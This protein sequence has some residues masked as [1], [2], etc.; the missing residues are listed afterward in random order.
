M[1]ILGADESGGSVG[2]EGRGRRDAADLDYG[3]DVVGITCL[4][5]KTVT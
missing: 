2:L 3:H 1:L 5:M 4:G